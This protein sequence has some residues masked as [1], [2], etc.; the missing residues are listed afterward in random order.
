LP[1]ARDD[2]RPAQFAP[3][4]DR[5]HSVSKDAQ[6]RMQTRITVEE[7]QAAARQLAK[8]ERGREAMKRFVALLSEGEFD[9]DLL[10]Q[11]AFLALLGGVWNGRTREVRATMTQA[12]ADGAGSPAS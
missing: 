4:N 6:K 5:G 8:T 12:L 2:R 10:D 1:S 3:T 9:L 11:R 7:M